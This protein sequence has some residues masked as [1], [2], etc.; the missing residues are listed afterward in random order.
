[1][2]GTVPVMGTVRFDRRG[3]TL[4]RPQAVHP[5]G[6]DEGAGFGMGFLYFAGAVFFIQQKIF[7]HVL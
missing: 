4:G 5:Q 3:G 7:L 1:M 2:R 6:A